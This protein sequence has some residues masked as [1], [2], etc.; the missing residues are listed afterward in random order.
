MQRTVDLSTL[1]GAGVAPA[2]TW[3]RR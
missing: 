1:R 2:A 3:G